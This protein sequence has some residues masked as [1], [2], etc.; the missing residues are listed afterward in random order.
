MSSLVQRCLPFVT[1]L[2]LVNPYPLKLL[3]RSVP[4]FPLQWGSGLSET[5]DVSRD[6]KLL[7]WSLIPMHFAKTHD[8]FLRAENGQC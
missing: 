6:S 2:G 7:N 1:L 8:T 5:G 3:F 4:S